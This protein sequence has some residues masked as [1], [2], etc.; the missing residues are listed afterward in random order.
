MLERLVCFSYSARS[1]AWVTS[2]HFAVPPRSGV[3][4]P[5]A[6]TCTHRYRD[7]TR[8]SARRTHAL[9]SAVHRL[10][11]FMFTQVLQ[12]HL[13]RQ[14]LRERVDG[15]AACG[16]CAFSLRTQRQS[17]K[18]YVPA[19]SVAEPCAGSKRACVSL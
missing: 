2:L 4:M 5:S 9:H 8:R 16:V 14:D 18:T 6:S 11:C 13:R 3:A 1:S 7:R 17:G 10:G 15:V 19:M 12:H